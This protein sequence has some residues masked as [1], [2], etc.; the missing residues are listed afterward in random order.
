[1]ITNEDPTRLLEDGLSQLDFFLGSIIGFAAGAWMVF[2]GL[3]FMK[4]WTYAYF[5]LLDKLYDRLYVLL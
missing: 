1:M 2:C 4:K 5:V 3:L